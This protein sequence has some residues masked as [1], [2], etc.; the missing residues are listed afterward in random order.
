ML[1]TINK[2]NTLRSKVKYISLI[3]C[4]KDVLPTITTLESRIKAISTLPIPITTK[5][6]KLFLG[7]MIFLS[8]FMPKLSELKK[9]KKL[10]TS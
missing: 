10:I 5:G 3:L 2:I 9:N 7:Y 6:I 8:Q 4:I 1:L